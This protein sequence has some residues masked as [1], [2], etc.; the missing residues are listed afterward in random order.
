MGYTHSPARRI[1]L[2]RLAS[3]AAAMR[4]APS[5]GA[6]TR[7]LQLYA[8]RA[9]ARYAFPTG[10][11]FGPDRQRAFLDEAAAQGLLDGVGRATGRQASTAELLRFHVPEYVAR[12]A[13]AET[14]GEAMLDDGD[15]PVFPGLDAAARR[16]VGAALAGLSDLLDGRALR[17]LQPIGGLHHARPD[18]AAGFCVYNDAGVVIAS[19]RR[20]HG[21]ARVAYVDIDAHHGDGVFYPFE[22]DPGVIIADVHQ[23]HRTLFP[24]TGRADETGRGEAVGT[25]RNVELPPRA[26]DAEFLGAWPALEAHLARHRPQFFLLQAGADGL[27]GD[28][29]AQLAYTPAV[30]AH[31]ARRL[32]VLADAHAQG[33]LMVLGGGGYDRRNVAL[34]WCAVLRELAGAS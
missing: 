32:R 19:L 11:P 31:F 24:G 2:A 23:D 27:A 5:F 18:G 13:R 30:H 33:R 6:E 3:V 29:L 16:V 8:G 17:T 4:A 20:L 1:W 10:H 26:G 7:P 34:A 12:V 28:P 9:L 21:L 14:A 25:K 15:T 22:D